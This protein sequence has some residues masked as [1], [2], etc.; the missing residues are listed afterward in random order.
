MGISSYLTCYLT[1]LVTQCNVSVVTDWDSSG[2]LSALIETKDIGKYFDKL[3]FIL[4]CQY[5]Y[6]DNVNWSCWFGSYML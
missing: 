4:W 6:L 1:V 3:F 5:R 2:D